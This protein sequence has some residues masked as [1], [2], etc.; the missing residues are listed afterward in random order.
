[1]AEQL[2]AEMEQSRQKIE[3]VSISVDKIEKVIQILN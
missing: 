3:A 2:T 1:M